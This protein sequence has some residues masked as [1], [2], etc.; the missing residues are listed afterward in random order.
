M[1]D[2]K[3]RETEVEVQEYKRPNP[4]LTNREIIIDLAQAQFYCMELLPQILTELKNIKQ[5]QQ[6]Q[7]TK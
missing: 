5:W 4:D 7:S 1:L 3:E 2:T 6:N